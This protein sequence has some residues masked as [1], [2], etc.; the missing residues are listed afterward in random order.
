MSESK[1]RR[2]FQLHLST[3]ILQWCVRRE[4]VGEKINLLEPRYTGC[5]FRSM[6]MRGNWTGPLES[7]TRNCIGVNPIW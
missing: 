1:P 2:W 7:I 3:V 6:G 4:R 5:P